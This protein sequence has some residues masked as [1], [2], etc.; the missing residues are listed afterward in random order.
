[1]LQDRATLRHRSRKRP[2]AATVAQGGAILQHPKRPLWMLPEPAPLPAAEGYP[3]H[4]G[5]L[6]LIDGPERLETGWWD[7]DGIAR[8]YYTAVNPQGMRL[9]VFRNRS[10]S[11]DWYL[12][13]FFG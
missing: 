4:H 3:L 10:R 2:L 8:D 6:R 12:H 11:A 13:G 9:W 1:M 7:E 5:P